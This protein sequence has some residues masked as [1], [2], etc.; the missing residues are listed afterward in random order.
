[1]FSTSSQRLAHRPL[2]LESNPRYF[3]GGA[4]CAILLTGRTHWSTLQRNGVAGRPPPVDYTEYLDRLG[5]S[6][7]R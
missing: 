4:G 5:P 7:T 2:S 3:T 6:A 1:M